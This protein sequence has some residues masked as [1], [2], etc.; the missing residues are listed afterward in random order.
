[1]SLEFQCWLV[2]GGVRDRILN[3]HPKD[4]DYVIDCTH[5]QFVR[6][7]LD[8]GHDLLVDKSEYGFYKIRYKYQVEGVNL[9][10]VRD[11]LLL[12]NST[13]E[14]NLRERDFT[15]NSMAREVLSNGEL[16]ELVDPFGGFIHLMNQKLVTT[17]SNPKITFKADPVRLLRLFRFSY[18]MTLDLD[19]KLSDLLDDQIWLD[20]AIDNLGGE[21]PD[22]VKQSLQKLLNVNSNYGLINYLGRWPAFQSYVLN[23]VKLVP[24]L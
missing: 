3:E 20:H 22:R 8:S 10:E 11:Y 23:S 2:G 5:D 21:S 14:D 15:I 18:Q 17:Y 19:P 7:L 12:G 1:M 13:I 24:N 16:G 6:W 4:S 9:T